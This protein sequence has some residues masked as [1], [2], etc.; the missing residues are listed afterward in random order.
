MRGEGKVD[1]GQVVLE[2]WHGELPR[3]FGLHLLVSVLAKQEKLVR[4]QQLG[5]EKPPWEYMK[6]EENP[7]LL[8]QEGK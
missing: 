7:R 3:H 8:F 1:Y 4:E 2:D 5:E 6:E